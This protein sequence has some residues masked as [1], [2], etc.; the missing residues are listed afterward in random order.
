MLGFCDRSLD[1]KELMITSNGLSVLEVCREFR[2]FVRLS[3]ELP[4]GQPSA[5]CV[6]LD[7]CQNDVI[8]ILI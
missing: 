7:S 4:N 5:Q 2:K 3:V 8:G 1:R 6:F